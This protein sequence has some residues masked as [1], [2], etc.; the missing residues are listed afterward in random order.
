MNRM[1][2]L[3]V[4]LVAMFAAG[5]APAGEITQKDFEL[6]ADSRFGPPDGKPRFWYGK[7]PMRDVETGE[8]L[9]TFEYYDTIRHYIDPANP[10]RRFGIARKLDLFRDKNTNQVLQTFNGKPVKS[11]VFP[12]QLLE[13][14]YK[15]GAIMLT[16]TQGS[17]EFLR[18]HRFPQTSIERYGQF[19]HITIP[20]YFKVTR[21]EIP[22]SV[23]THTMTSNFI[24]CEG[25]C[26]SSP[27]HQW[28]QAGIS[29][30][31][32]WAGGDG[33]KMAY[34]FMS[35]ARFENYSDLPQQLRSVIEAQYPQ[36]REPPRDLEEIKA[37]QRAPR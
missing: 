4:L 6:W 21:P 24:I 16:A 31:A 7:G 8:T 5:P 33:R 20:G 9:Y 2:L 12:Y 25:A 11:W 26:G 18:V 32:P 17:G 23:Q 22:D 15:D 27:R 30:L 29:P 34:M 19:A 36:W 1:S 14:E 3:A 35:G 10:N 28:M 13:M 37:I